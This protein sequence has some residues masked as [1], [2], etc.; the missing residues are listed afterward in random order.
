MNTNAIN[1]T[2]T[3]ISKFINCLNFKKFLF[4]FDSDNIISI[5]GTFF[6]KEDNFTGSGQ[7]E[8][9][10]AEISKNG[11]LDFKLYVEYKHFY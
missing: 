6:K 5:L 1:F 9:V 7:F 4:R 3:I 2:C 10:D 8:N 11:L